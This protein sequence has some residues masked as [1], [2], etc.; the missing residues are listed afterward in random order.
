MGTRFARGGPEMTV[1]SPTRVSGLRRK[2]CHDVRGGRKLVTDDG[3]EKTHR[4]IEGGG[5][6]YRSQGE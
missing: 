2:G 1:E 5:P 4:G 6:D 3:L